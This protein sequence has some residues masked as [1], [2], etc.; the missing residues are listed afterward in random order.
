LQRRRSDAA[1]ALHSVCL[2]RCLL[3]VDCGR[4]QAEDGFSARQA[5][6]CRHPCQVLV[7]LEGAVL[8]AAATAPSFSAR[9]PLDGPASLC[10]AA[11]ASLTGPSF[12]PRLPRRC[13][14]PH[15]RRSMAPL[16][17]VWPP[18]RQRRLLPAAAM[19]PFFSPRPPLDSAMA[20]ASLLMIR[21]DLCN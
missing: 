10:A 4:K 12:T 2:P 7:L 5:A 3:H 14:S 6:G 18:A 9:P 21:P 1:A 11:F 13:P 20:I 8:A 16:V 17:S 15:G 19:A